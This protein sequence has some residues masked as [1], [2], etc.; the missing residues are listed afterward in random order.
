LRG[1]PYFAL[2]AA[3]QAALLGYEKGYELPA[4]ETNDGLETTV[5][6]RHTRIRCPK[7]L[8]R[9]KPIRS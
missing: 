7:R 4:R 8:M 3:L 2:A 9:W 1:Q 6:D 5:T